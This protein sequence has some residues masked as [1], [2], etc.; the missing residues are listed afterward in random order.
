M[1]LAV[2]HEENRVAY[3]WDAT[4]GRSDR[5]T[6]PEPVS[7]RHLLSVFPGWPRYEPASVDPDPDIVAAQ[8]ALREPGDRPSYAAFREELGL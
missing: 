5:F 4:C 1:A 2:T 6:K 7:S 8:M 3:A